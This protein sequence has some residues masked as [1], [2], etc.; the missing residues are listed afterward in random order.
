MT[1]V[2]VFIASD[3][4][5]Q[6]RELTFGSY[7][8]LLDDA[9]TMA[10]VAAAGSE[11]V[12]L[13]LAYPQAHTPTSRLLSLFVLPAYRGR[14]VGAQLVQAIEREAADQGDTM[15][16]TAY[17]A[18]RDALEGVLARCG[19][20]PP[21]VQLNIIEAPFAALHDRINAH[22]LPPLPAGA[23]LFPWEAR[24]PQDEQ[25]AQQYQASLGSALHP[26]ADLHLLQPG[27][28]GVRLGE[29]LVGWAILH[30]I[31]P[32]VV[33]CTALYVAPEARYTGLWQH[34]ICETYRRQMRVK[35]YSRMILPSMPSMARFLRRTLGSQILSTRELRVCEKAL[36]PN[37]SPEK[38]AHWQ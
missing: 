4:L 11:P 9:R 34:L 23:A 36:S 18:P 14:G 24:T 21:R 6:Y 31:A 12:G 20:G 5:P 37:P 19:W 10:A 17:V 16:D 15:I 3:N 1:A 28:T 33:R 8:F 29:A 22:P 38:P 30:E 27:S 25:Q 2:E 32:E 26:L 13:A 7:E 35:P